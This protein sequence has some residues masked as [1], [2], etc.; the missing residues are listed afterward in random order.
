MAT[1]TIPTTTAMTTPIT[2]TTTTTGRAATWCRAAVIPVIARSATGP[3][4]RRQ[5]PI[6]ATT[7]CAIPAA[8]K[9]T[10]ATK[11]KSGSVESPFFFFPGFFH[12]GCIR[13]GKPGSG[14]TMSV[15]DKKTK[16]TAPKKEPVPGSKTAEVAPKTEGV[17]TEAVKTEGVK[18]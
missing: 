3:G 12:A 8:S 1:A 16:S 14:K 5:G 15:D 10:L 17:K 18:I 4:I 11:S 13:A 2:I 6:S 7:A 9:D